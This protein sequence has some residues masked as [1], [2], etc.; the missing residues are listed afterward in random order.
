MEPVNKARIAYIAYSAALFALG[1]V[2]LF[3]PKM[4]TAVMCGLVGGIL[5][6]CGAL[7][8]AAYFVNDTY[9][10]AFQFD[11]A[12]G[13][14]TAIIGVLLLIHPQS[15]ISFLDPMFG[16]FI[17][18]DGVFKLQTAREAKQFG[19][20]NWQLIL[21][22]AAVTVIIGLLLVI[23]AFGSASVAL[24]T[25][26]ALMSDGLQNLLTA[27]LDIKLVKRGKRVNPEYKMGD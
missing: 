21:V 1:C 2:L 15:L 19:L 27:L 17:L 24:I 7:R 20:H 13:I 23:D 3:F 26:I 25:G 4:S 8:L 11:F 22:P 9:G 5:V 14:F 10:L 16:V 12:L 18:A 6:L